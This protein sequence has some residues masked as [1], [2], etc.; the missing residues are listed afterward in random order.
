MAICES[1]YQH[2]HTIQASQSSGIRREVVNEEERPADMTS[3]LELVGEMCAKHP[4][5]TIP[6]LPSP[7]RESAVTSALRKMK[8]KVLHTPRAQLS[9]ASPHTASFLAG[10]SPRSPSPHPVYSY[11]PVGVE[12]A[13]LSPGS[14]SADPMSPPHLLSPPNL[15]ALSSSPG[16]LPPSPPDDCELKPSFVSLVPFQ[17]GV[18][19]IDGQDSSRRSPYS[20]LIVRTYSIASESPPDSTVAASTWMWLEIS[21]AITYAFLHL[22]PVDPLGEETSDF[23]SF[24]RCAGKVCTVS[25][26]LRQYILTRIVHKW[27]RR[28]RCVVVVMTMVKLEWLCV[29]M[30]CGVVSQHSHRSVVGSCVASCEECRSIGA[31]LHIAGACPLVFDFISLRFLIGFSPHRIASFVLW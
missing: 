3:L 1:I 21:R 25:P 14:S 31:S 18:E 7:F 19:Q 2:V 23:G 6:R 12:E 5:S 9:V 29:M 15:H 13:I 11:T 10:S 4:P 24:V 26:V 30:V 16:H 22:S 28:N 17:E 8:P 20:N 27:P